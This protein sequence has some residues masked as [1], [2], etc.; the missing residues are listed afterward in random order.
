MIIAG[1]SI[2]IGVVMV[3]SIITV[4]LVYITVD[5]KCT[6]CTYKIHIIFFERAVKAC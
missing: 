4:F 1:V 6:I 5:C 2:G 3:T